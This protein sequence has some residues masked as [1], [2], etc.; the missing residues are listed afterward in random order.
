MATPRDSEQTPLLQNGS[1]HEETV[2]FDKAGDDGN[3]REWPLGRKY[4]QVIQ[5]ALLAFIC[6]MASSVFAPAVSEIADEFQIPSQAV[7]A[8]QTGLVCML[9]I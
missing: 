6:P 7:L 4:F 1:N 9:G 2:D 5:I 8:G 3:P